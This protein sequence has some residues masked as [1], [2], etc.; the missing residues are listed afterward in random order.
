MPVEELQG[1]DRRTYF[2]DLPWEVRDRASQWLQKFCARWRHDLPS[3]RLARLVGQ[4]RRLA[5][6]TPEERSAWGRRMQARHGGL[7]VQR[8]YR[9]QGRDTLT[10]ARYIRQLKQQERK[11][12][13]AEDTRRKELGLPLPRRSKLLPFG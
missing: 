9:E 3:W 12:V 1:C 10:R 8:M 4:A 11:R 13:A 7:A 5:Q 2:D 6:T